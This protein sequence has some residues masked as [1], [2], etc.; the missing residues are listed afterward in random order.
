MLNR[1][2]DFINHC[3]PNAIIGRDYLYRVV[4]TVLPISSKESSCMHLLSDRIFLLDFYFSAPHHPRATAL[5]VS[6]RTYQP[7]SALGSQTDPKPNPG[8]LWGILFI[9]LL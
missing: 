8:N 4:D 2:I 5:T 7:L 6:M 3:T 9:F 1:V